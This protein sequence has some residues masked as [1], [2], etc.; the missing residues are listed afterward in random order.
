MSQ[1]FSVF[2][3]LLL[4]WHSQNGNNGLK[5]KTATSWLTEYIKCN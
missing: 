3:H 2:A 1:P 4:H 5:Q